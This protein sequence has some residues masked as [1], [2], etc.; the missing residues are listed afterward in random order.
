MKRIVGNPWVGLVSL[1]GYVAVFILIDAFIAAEKAGQDIP[2]A[3]PSALRGLG[4]VCIVGIVLA[5]R[6]SALQPVWRA[7]NT[8]TLALLA[9]Q[10]WV[11]FRTWGLPETSY[12]T[13]PREAA[14]SIAFILAIVAALGQLD[15]LPRN[16]RHGWIAVAAVAVPGFI[17]LLITSRLST[18]TPRPFEPTMA[19]FVALAA[20]L[21]A[22]FAYD[23][24]SRSLKRT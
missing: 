23:F 18:A 13:G 24:G 1:G 22:P 12:K 8:L 17:G 14:M 6:H 19:V 11:V 9:V 5:Q 16:H 10:A 15:S 3:L 4:V 7:M 2:G 20:A 21:S